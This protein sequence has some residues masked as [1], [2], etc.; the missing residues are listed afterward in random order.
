[1]NESSTVMLT[2]AAEAGAKAGASLG[3]KEA[4]SSG[5]IAGALAGAEAGQR[6]GA[7]AGAKAAAK[8]ATIVATKTLKEALQQLG[9]INKPVSLA[10]NIIIYN[11]L[12]SFHLFGQ[13]HKQ[14]V[15]LL[16]K[17]TFLT[18]SVRLFAGESSTTQTLKRHGQNFQEVLLVLQM[19]SWM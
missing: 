10:C 13:E 8:A 2:V 9:K 19:E 7:E 6:A 3:M 12:S 17:E 11:L 16:I 5:Q 18:R 1:M 15:L 14:Q 4:Q